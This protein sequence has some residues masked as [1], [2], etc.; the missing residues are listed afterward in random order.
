VL[1]TVPVEA[2]VVSLALVN[3]EGAEKVHSS[4]TVCGMSKPGSTRVTTYF[5]PWGM[6]KP[7]V[8]LP[9]SMVAAVPWSLTPVTEAVPTF[10][11]GTKEHPVKTKEKAIRREWGVRVFI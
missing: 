7:D 6:S 2:R 9:A 8:A 5:E 1:S 4:T 3:R 11:L 10:A